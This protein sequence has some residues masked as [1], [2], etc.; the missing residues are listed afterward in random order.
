M[1]GQLTKKYVKPIYPN[2]N[3]GNSNNSNNSSSNTGSNSNTTS[4]NLSQDE[5]EVFDLI[6][7]QKN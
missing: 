4:S 1:L 6:N 7:K 2:N 3:T 5:K